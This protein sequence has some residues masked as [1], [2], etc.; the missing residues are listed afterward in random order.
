MNVKIITLTLVVVFIASSFGAIIASS[1]S[2][3]ADTITVTDGRGETVTF[4]SAVDS[5]VTVGRGVT[6]T[7]IQLGMLDKIVVCDKY[8]AG[9]T[10]KVFDGLREYVAE[11]KISASGSVYSSGVS[12]LKNEIIDATDKG[13]FDKTSDALIITGSP[14]YLD[15]GLIDFFETEG[16]KKILVWYDTKIT[17][18]DDIV[19]VVE[20]ISKVTKGTVDPVVNEM[21]SLPK[22]ID[23]ILKDNDITSDSDKAEAFYV[24]YS[25]NAYKVGNTGSLATAMILAAGGNVV[26]LD[27]SQTA[28]T[29]EANL[30]QIIEEYGKDVV[31]FLDD[32][33][34]STDKL[35][36]VRAMVGNEVKLVPLDPLYNNYTVESMNCVKLMA[37]S[38]Y[39]DIFEGDDPFI[40][41]E[42]DDDNLL[43]YVAAGIV[44]VI[45][46]IGVAFVFMRGHA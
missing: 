6:A 11:G 30:T 16:Y 31:I 25:G 22:N 2:E 19:D 36:D 21:R 27:L 38:M 4:D 26:T 13:K 8:S 17:S 29:Y 32:N 41:S 20:V 40:P 39:P 33:I 1:D 46:I 24:T 44:A 12:D 23:T 9:D 3:G 14:T 7:T 42:E 37:H 18:Y 15:N 45:V 28:S 34:A 5:I 35:N 43:I 10:N